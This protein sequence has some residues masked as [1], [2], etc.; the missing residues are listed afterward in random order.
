MKKILAILLTAILLCGLLT[1]CGEAPTPAPKDDNG[2]TEL[3]LTDW[4]RYISAEEAM[5][6]DLDWAIS[7]ITAFGEQPEWSTLLSARAAVELA[8]KR[9]E[10]RDEPAWDAPEEAYGYFM[11]R[12]VDVSFV[13]PE[14]AGFEGSRQSLLITCETL[15]QNLMSDVFTRDGLSRTVDTAAIHREENNISLT[16]LALT[17]D[18]LLLQLDDT[19]WTEKVHE[20]MQE[21]SPR[22]SAA[23]NPVLTTAEDLENAA[24][25]TLESLSAVVT[26]L[27]S[28]VGRGQA[29]LDLLREYTV[30]GD[31]ASIL[32]MYGTIEGLPALLPD[33]GWDLAEADYFWT[34]E[35]GTRRY[36][37]KK[38]DLTGPPEHCVLEFANV[39]EDE[40]VEYISYLYEV[41]GLNGDWVDGEDGYY[42]VYFQCGD[43]VLSVSWT[44]KGAAIYMLSTPVCL[45]PEWFIIA[46]QT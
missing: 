9:I 8:A 27:T 26:E 41:L 17:T 16:Y 13:Q 34:D 3:I 46:N 2:Y 39:T 25:D 32:A 24:S 22:I 23:R 7:Y 42:N 4:M 12:E 37:T 43:S 14:L 33:P 30:R 35:D 19:E 10:R 31:T 15:R 21:F 44:E 28:L 29:E 11:D 1:A 6:E 18:Y 45:A 38:E 5:Y 36:L 20:S 40:V